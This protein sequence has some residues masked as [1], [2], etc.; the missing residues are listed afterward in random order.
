MANTAKVSITSSSNED[1]TEVL[2]KLEALNQ[3]P[4][5][6]DVLVAALRMYIEKT[7]KM[8]AGVEEKIPQPTFEEMKKSGTIYH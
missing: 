1:D 2:L 8:V 5:T 4:I 3:E 6:V 7:E